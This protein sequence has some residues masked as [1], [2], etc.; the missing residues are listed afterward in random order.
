MAWLFVL[1][2]GMGEVSGVMGLKA[3]S[4]KKNFKNVLFTAISFG[5]SFGFLSLAFQSISMSTAYALWTGMGTL[6]S[7]ILGIVIYREPADRVRLICM[8]MIL[9][10]AVGLKIIS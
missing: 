5:F 1:I 10:G 7:T 4:I 2:S 6:G 9:A 3:L 8:S